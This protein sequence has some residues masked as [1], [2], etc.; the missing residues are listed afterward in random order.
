MKSQWF[1]DVIEKATRSVVKTLGP[2]S[3]E[4]NAEKAERGVLINMNTAEF[5]TTVRAAP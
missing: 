5:F 4:R 2:Y 1:V 3:S